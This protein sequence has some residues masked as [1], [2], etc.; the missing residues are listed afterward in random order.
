MYV[1]CTQQQVSLKLRTQSCIAVLQ[2][3][4]YGARNRVL[5]NGIRERSTY[6]LDC[7]DQAGY[8]DSRMRVDAAL[9]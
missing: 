8:V 5:E 9:V 6:L 1:I 2:H 7:R 3:A 4:V